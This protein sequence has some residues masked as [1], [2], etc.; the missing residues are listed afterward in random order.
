MRFT[1]GEQADVRRRRQVRLHPAIQAA[2]HLLA[3][4]LSLQPWQHGDIADLQVATAI[5]HDAAHRYQLIA[6]VGTHAIQGVGQCA[7]RRLLALGTEAGQHTQPA[8]VFNR[9][10][11]LT[12]LAADGIISCGI[13]L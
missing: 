5:T 2:H 11:C 3:Q 6:L 7:R 8:V 4:P 1:I 9:G 12:E 10:D 13:S